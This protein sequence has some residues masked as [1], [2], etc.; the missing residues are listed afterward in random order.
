MTGNGNTALGLNALY[1]NTNG[2]QNTAV[3][4]DA[5]LSNVSGSYDT[6]SGVQALNSNT[7]GTGNTATGM[8][9]LSSNTV[10]VSDTATG[11]LS[12]SRN[13]SGNN[14]A[15]YG[16]S[17]L[18]YN[19]TGN[20]N[21]GLG[22]SAL[23]NNTSGTGNIAVG[24]TAGLNLTSGSNNIEIGNVGVAAESN[25]TRIGTSQSSA[26][27]AG[28]YGAVA[29]G[30]VA[31]YVNSSGQLGTSPSSAKYKEAIQ[32]MDKASEAI[33]ALQPVTFRYK[34]ELD[35]KAIAQFGL[36]AEEVAKVDPDLVARDNDGKIYT[37][38][39]E[40]VNAML[41][42]EFLKEHRKVADQGDQIAELKATVSGA[43]IGSQSAGR[44]NPE[45]ERP[46]QNTSSCSSCGGE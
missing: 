34:K 14:N 25:T 23:S 42:N 33:L 46:A 3:G 20:K 29:S 38:R 15:G 12:L 17:A 5:L 24:Y 27:L 13:T 16:E 10:G 35:P 7:T 36:V 19:T 43:E 8:Q 2:L 1:G 28:V 41:L 9:A 39:Y 45:G 26:F 11:Y 22:V 6:A 30:G 32:P 4:V 40:A 21:T 44:A 18:S 31:V 37:V